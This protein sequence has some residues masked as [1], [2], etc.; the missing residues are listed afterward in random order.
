M[1][2]LASEV[3]GAGGLGQ[4]RER[5]LPELVG[6]GLP[7][8]DCDTPPHGDGRDRAVR[9]A[10]EL[11]AEQRGIGFR[12]QGQRGGGIA[13]GGEEQKGG[14]ANHVPVG[15]LEVLRVDDDARD[16]AGADKAARERRARLEVVLVETANGDRIVGRVVSRRRVAVLV[17]DCAGVQ[18]RVSGSPANAKYDRKPRINAR[19]SASAQH[20]SGF[21]AI[22]HTQHI[23]TRSPKHVS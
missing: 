14:I 19:K 22:P 6:D 20:D 8:R 3:R 18:N 9:V 12:V 4:G 7:A 15:G 23:T 11:R 13:R 17:R 5:D 1:V 21:A 10:R 16:L 2:T